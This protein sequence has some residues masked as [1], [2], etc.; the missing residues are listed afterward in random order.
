[1]SNDSYSI[2]VAVDSTDAVTATR[3]LSSMEQATGRSERALQGLTKTAVGLVALDRLAA[4][5]KDILDVNRSMEMLRACLLYT[6]PS[7]RD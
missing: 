5:G 7:P 4:L 3:N 1:M 2:H 6:S